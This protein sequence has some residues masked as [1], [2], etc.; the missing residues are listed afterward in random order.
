M[1]QWQ[2]GLF[3]SPVRLTVRRPLAYTA[4]VVRATAATIFAGTML[5][6]AC[7]RVPSGES[8]GAPGR[9]P[10]PDDLTG[11]TAVLARSDV[12][13]LQHASAALVRIGP[14]AI[15]N[16]EA[17]LADRRL[18]VRLAAIRGLAALGAPATSALGRGLRDSD[19]GVRRIAC[20]ALVAIGP[21]TVE[22][23]RAALGAPNHSMREAAVA[24]AGRL[25]DAAAALLPSVLGDADGRVRAEGIGAAVAIGSAALPALEAALPSLS[26]GQ[27]NA[28]E[29][30]IAEIRERG[31][32]SPAA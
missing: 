22:Q 8:G 12:Y 2:R 27:R 20:D 10:A 13:D 17:A 21:S 6:A 1:R 30:A 18:D 32:A 31:G 7:T 23:F 15:P 28:V 14:P 19:S 16:L 25:G 4:L 11:W 5:L 24:C 26:G 9:T 29:R 3:P